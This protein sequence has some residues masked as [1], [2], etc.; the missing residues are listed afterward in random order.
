MDLLRNRPLATCCLCFLLCLTVAAYTSSTAKLWL[1]AAALLACL[2][3]LFFKRRRGK[4]LRLLCFILAFSALLYGY[5]RFDRYFTMAD[6]YGGEEVTVVARVREITYKQ[7][8]ALAFIADCE[9]VAGEAADRR[10][11]VWAYTTTAP[12]EGDRIVFQA[13]L[14]ALTG[15]ESLTLYQRARGIA[16][17]AEDTW[18]ID[19]LPDS[20]RDPRTVVRRFFGDLRLSLGNHISQNSPG[21]GG[22]LMRALLLGEQELIPD[23][24]NLAFRRTGISHV[25]SLSGLHLSLLVGGLATLFCRLHVPRAPTV[26]CQ[27]LLVLFYM[28]LTGFSISI[29]R[30]GLMMLLFSL[31]FFAR[32]EADG[33]T[34]LSLAACGIAIFSPFAVYDCGYWLSVVATFG[35]LVRNEWQ[36][37]RPAPSGHL[38]RLLHRIGAS[39]SVT[40]AATFATLPLT[41]LYFGEVSLLTPLCNLLLIPLF[42]LYL[43]LA[44]LALPLGPL[45]FLG[46][47]FDACG[48]LLLRLVERMASLRGIMLSIHEPPVKVLLSVSAVA[49]LLCLCLPHVGKKRTAVVGLSLLALATISLTAINI[50]RAGTTGVHYAHT[51]DNELM[52]VQ[53]GHAGL[54]CDLSGGSYTAQKAG[55]KVVKDAG[56]AELDGYLLTHYHARHATSLPRLCGQIIIRTIYLPVPSSPEEEEIYR[57]IKQEATALGVTCTLYQPYTDIAFGSLTLHPHAHGKSASSHPTIAISVRHNEKLLTYLGAGHHESD[58]K[59]LAADAVAKSQILLFGTHGGKETARPSFTRFASD[60]HCV[61]LPQGDRLPPSLYQFLSEKILLANEGTR[62]YLPL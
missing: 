37:K 54:L 42:D 58:Q 28:A 30:S 18:G 47:A 8:G 26:I 29:L 7:G 2:L 14:H 12:A 51:S 35:I 10:L 27:C 56:L 19:P 44:V 1:G 3:S 21:R 46:E 33:I 48:E 53:S 15:E 32:R 23:S 38:P 57:T 61:V 11:S 49:V 62:Q 59:R 60:L 13:T 43:F 41:A 4:A 17:C 39:L 25:L 31:S 34:S 40:L 9:T 6:A 36:E 16:A 45:P 24:V 55:L 5:I 20:T 52:L 50:V 22:L